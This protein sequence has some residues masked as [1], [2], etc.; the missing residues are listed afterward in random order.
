MD[1]LEIRGIDDLFLSMPKGIT[2]EVAEPFA[3]HVAT[4]A[5]A[6]RSQA[7]AL[8]GPDIAVGGKPWMRLK[9]MLDIMAASIIPQAEQTIAEFVAATDVQ[10]RAGC[11]FCCHQNVDVTI[12]EA[13]L[14]ALQLGNEGDPRPAAVLEAA[15]V[16]RDIDDDAR[17]ATGKPCALLVDNHCSVYNVRPIACRSLTSPDASR[18]HSAMQSL[19]AGDGP[20]PIEIYVVLQFLCMGEQ[21]AI[22][23]LC[24]DL[25]L[26]TDLVELTQAVAA[27]LRDHTLIERWATGER[28]FTARVTD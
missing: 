1:S 17:I 13:I 2:E 15:D 25:G 5:L 8:A 4:K 26:Q 23:G 19:A 7:M 20:Q 21:G 22:R 27:I 14:V 10:C 16:F 9:F 18:C 12:P 6:L 11:S 3:E 28:V 24:R